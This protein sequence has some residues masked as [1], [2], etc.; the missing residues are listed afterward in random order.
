VLVLQV[1]LL[2]RLGA[3]PTRAAAHLQREAEERAKLDA[4]ALQEAV[5]KR[6]EAIVAL[7]KS[8]QEQAAEDWRAQFAASQLRAEIAEGRVTAAAGVVRELRELVGDLRRLLTELPERGAGEAP[9]PA[10]AAPEADPEGQRNTMEMQRPPASCAP[11][12]A[13]EPSEEGDGSEEDTRVLDVDAAS[14]RAA[15]LR[16]PLRALPPPPPTEDEHAS[17]LPPASGTSRR[18]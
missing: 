8:Y 16:A 3:V 1:A 14:V 9:A 18:S 5:R 10:S 7:L 15:V 2:L 4:N 6:V 12:S 13:A 11:S 17:L